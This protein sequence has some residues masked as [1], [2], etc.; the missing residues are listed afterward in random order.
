MVLPC[1]AEAARLAPSQVLH[2]RIRDHGLQ[3][4]QH[5]HICASGEL[6]RQSL[7][8]LR[9]MIMIFVNISISYFTQLT[10]ALRW[11]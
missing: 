10:S 3:G 4:S 1:I 6:Q 2:L 9:V 11:T 7:Y 5:H 8:L